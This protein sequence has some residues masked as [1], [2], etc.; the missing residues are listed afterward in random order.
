HHEFPKDYRNGLHPLDWDPTKWLIWISGRLGLAWDLYTVPENEIKKAMILTAEKKSNE[1]RDKVDWGPDPTLL[2][3]MT[4]TEMAKAVSEDGKELMAIDGYVLDVSTFK[5][6]HPG[7]SKILKGYYGKDATQT[8]FKGTLN[9]HSL[10]A[11]TY[12]G[13]LRVAKVAGEGEN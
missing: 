12:L 3:T 8:F 2:P 4:M 13:M 5:D 6:R 7:G 1:I 10:S 9:N 11:R